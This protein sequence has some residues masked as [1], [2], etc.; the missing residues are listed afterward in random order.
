[1]TSERLVSNAEGVRIGDNDLLCTREHRIRAIPMAQVGLEDTDYALEHADGE[2]H[3]PLMADLQGP[4]RS[5]LSAFSPAKAGLALIP[6][7]GPLRT[8][9]L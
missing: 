6:A 4:A 5:N 8:L 1:M 3:S 7:H 2:S 9:W